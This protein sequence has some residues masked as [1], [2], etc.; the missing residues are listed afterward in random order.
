[1]ATK[2]SVQVAKLSPATPTKNAERDW[3]GT[4]RK[5]SFTY[6]AAVGNETVGNILRAVKLPPG[7][8]VV[9]YWLQWEA[10][11]SAGG[12]AG[13]DVGLTG[14]GQRYLTAQDMDAAGA[15]R[16]TAVIDKMPDRTP[17]ADDATFFI[18]TVTGEAWLAAKK[19]QG[20]VEIVP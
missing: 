20:W 4:S 2:D 16:A 18:L 8:L 5:F 9:D 15:I 6:V 14:D 1:M 3:G 11:S 13:A 10:L 12:T 17:I 7:C 19:V